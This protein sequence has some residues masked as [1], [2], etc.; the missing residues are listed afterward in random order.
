MLSDKRR[1]VNAIRIRAVRFGPTIVCLCGSTRFKDE[2]IEQ[3]KQQTMQGKIVL[4]V[5]MFGHSGD[6]LSDN[7]KEKL[8]ALHKR[9]IDLAEEVL[10]ICPGGY[11][12]SSTR[13]ELAYAE[14]QG[15]RL[16][17]PYGRPS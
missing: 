13:S 11:I 4:S 9:K 17:F 10:F 16:I 3:N 15:K 7:D 5:G 14:E 6:E 1:K 12:G 2:Y 8:D